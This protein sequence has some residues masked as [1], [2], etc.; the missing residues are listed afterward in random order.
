MTDPL[1]KIRQDMHTF[2]GRISASDARWMADEG[3]VIIM[4]KGQKRGEIAV[5]RDCTD[6]WDFTYVDDPMMNFTDVVGWAYPPSRKRSDERES[7]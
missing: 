6:H 2:D 7:K 1:A 3:P 5:W 4:R